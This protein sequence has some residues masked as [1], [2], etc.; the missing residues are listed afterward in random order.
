M[1][2]SALFVVP[3][4]LALST[5]AWARH[6]DD[7]HRGDGD[8]RGEYH[9]NDRRGGYDRGGDWDHRNDRDRRDDWDRRGGRD[10]WNRGANYRGRAP[11]IVIAPYER[12]YIRGYYRRNPCDYDRLR[13]RP[14]IGIRVPYGIPCRPVPYGLSRGLPYYPGYERYVVGRDIILVAIATGLIV[15]VFFNAF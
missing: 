1:R 3:L 10:D 6:H 8:R 5:P 9:N 14:V 2:R 7:G 4:M 12:D 11:V 13:W 15:D